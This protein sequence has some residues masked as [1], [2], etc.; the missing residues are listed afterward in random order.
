[1]IRAAC[2]A[3]VDEAQRRIGNL[4][5]LAPISPDGPDW[6]GQMRAI[7]LPKRDGVTAE[8]L[9]ARLWDEY[10]IEIPVHEYGDYRLIRLSIQA[11]NSPADVDRLVSALAAIL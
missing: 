10:Q 6:W 8:A 4:T 5:G 9:Q 7:P 3:L 11:Y 2:H 1:M